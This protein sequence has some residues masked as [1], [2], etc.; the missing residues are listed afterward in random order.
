[1]KTI[2]IFLAVIL[3]TLSSLTLAREPL[4]T[5]YT[6]G[7]LET[8][9][10]KATVSNGVLTVAFMV[11][12]PTDEEIKL[13]PPFNPNQVEYVARDKRYPVLKD[14]NDQWMLSPLGET[15]F[16]NHLFSENDDSNYYVKFRPK[17]KKVGWV[18]FEA[19]PDDAWPIDLALPQTSP[20]TIEKPN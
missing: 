5:Q 10:L 18:K 1:M 9:L 20:F 3:F 15:V 2:H 11:E 14:A 17:E 12:N 6:S 13:H 8:H 7:G 16:N 19:P 4:D